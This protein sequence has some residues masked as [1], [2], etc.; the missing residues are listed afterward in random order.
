MPHLPRRRTLFVYSPVKNNFGKAP[1]DMFPVTRES[2][3]K[4]E[5]K[6]N[7]SILVEGRV[8]WRKGRQGKKKSV[9]N[10]TTF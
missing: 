5:E 9:R 6:K 3:K 4:T 7:L 2:G 8:G 1:I 10:L